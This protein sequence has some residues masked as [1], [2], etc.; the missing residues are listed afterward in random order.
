M[1]FQPGKKTTVAYT[2]AQQHISRLRT[3][4]EHV[5]KSILLML[6]YPS[7]K[8]SFLAHLIIYLH[9]ILSTQ[10][11]TWEAHSA[12]ISRFTLSVEVDSN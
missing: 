1:F 8:Y 12:F 10:Q 11:N 2:E 3:M 9:L 6:A 4:F 7:L 5:I